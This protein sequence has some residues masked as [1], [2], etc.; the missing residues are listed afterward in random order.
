MV[1][2][3]FNPSSC[4][5][6][7][8][9]SLWIPEQPGLLHRETCFGKKEK[10]K[11]HHLWLLEHVLRSQIK[12]SHLA[13]FI[14]KHSVKTSVP[15]AYSVEGM[16]FWWSGHGLSWSEGGKGPWAASTRPPFFLSSPI[17]SRELVGVQVQVCVQTEEL[18]VFLLSQE[19]RQVCPLTGPQRSQL[20]C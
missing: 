14:P 6:E 11:N 19:A 4:V 3:A 2:H 7:A 16:V 13:H 5:A 1:A 10:R 17:T 8:G 20:G 9:Q 18:Q 15:Q 12:K